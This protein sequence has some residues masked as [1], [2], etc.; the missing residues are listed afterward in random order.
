MV[1]PVEKDSFLAVMQ[2]E[3]IVVEVLIKNV[4]T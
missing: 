3:N 1:S 4:Q 2:K